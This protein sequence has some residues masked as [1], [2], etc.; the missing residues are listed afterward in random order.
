[1]KSGFVAII[2]RPNVGKSTLLNR[3]IGEKVVI[4]SD[5]PQTT[6]NSIKCI[7]TEKDFQIV[8]LDT[9]GIHK[10]KNKLGEYMVKAAYGTLE[11]VDAVLFMTECDKKMGPG[12]EYILES[13][14]EVETPVILVI[15]KVDQL[16]KEALAE[17]M[18]LYQEWADTYHLDEVI[19]ISAKEGENVDRLLQVVLSHLEEG[20][21]YFP[22]D[23]ITEQ[24]ERVIIAELIRE[25]ILK[26]TYDEVPHGIAVEVDQ[27]K[28]RD[29]GVVYVQATI[30]CEK[31]SHKHIIIGNNGQMLKKVGS[32]ARMDVQ[33]LLGAPVFLDLWVKVNEDWRNKSKSLNQFGYVSES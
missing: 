33:A 24:P 30:Y 3:L 12:D 19:P 20:P 11:E 17:R 23:M 26:N 5:K 4:M 7:L 21:Q 32:E 27:V 31:K 28:E 6:R 14:K 25:K 16:S 22:D 1:M 2:G 13:L 18:T 15:N 29:N 10:P 9:P 8:F